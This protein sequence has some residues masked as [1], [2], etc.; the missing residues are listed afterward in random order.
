MMSLSEME[1]EAEKLKVINLQ[2]GQTDLEK[3]QIDL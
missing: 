1:V 2:K 3:R